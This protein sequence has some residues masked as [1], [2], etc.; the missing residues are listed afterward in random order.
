MYKKCF[1]FFLFLLTANSFLAQNVGI[2]TDGSTPSAL[3]HVK[4]NSNT[5]GTIELM[6]FE[7]TNADVASNHGAFFSHYLNGTEMGRVFWNPAGGTLN[8]STISFFN[9][10][11]GSMNATPSLTLLHNR[12]VGIGNASPQKALDINSSDGGILI[13]RLADTTVVVSPKTGELIYG[14][15]AKAFFYYDGT[16]WSRMI[17][18]SDSEVKKPPYIGQ[19]TL[20]GIVFYVYHTGNV[21]HGLI[22]AKTQYFNGMQWQNPNSQTNGTD[23]WNGTANTAAMTNSPIKTWINTHL[24][25]DWYLP[26]IDELALMIESKYLLNACLNKA[27]ADPIIVGV[28]WSSTEVSSTQV[29]TFNPTEWAPREV[30]H[31]KSSV[32]R[33]RA[34]KAF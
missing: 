29:L 16:K 22:M 6:R 5:T 9:R 4:S 7:R 21:W 15:T 30:I 2:N 24:G 3:L 26:S 1:T 18:S 23:R 14:T 34:I 13:P 25:T 11:G 32:Y 17:K 28:Y 20:G 19:D 31:P 8:N 12:N 33:F 10:S 27:G